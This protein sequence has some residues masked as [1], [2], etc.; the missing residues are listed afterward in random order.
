MQFVSIYNFEIHP[1]QK[2]TGQHMTVPDQEMSIKEIMQRFASG[3]NV[4]GGRDSYYGGEDFGEEDPTQKMGFGVFDAEELKTQLDE[5]IKDKKQ[6]IKDVQ[7]IRDAKKSAEKQSEESVKQKG[8]SV[9]DDEK[10][11][12]IKERS[13]ADNR[14]AAENQ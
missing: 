14:E 5:T 10:Q 11:N 3:Q 8:S 13:S 1:G 4:L 7:S 9:A 6:K 2:I 12:A